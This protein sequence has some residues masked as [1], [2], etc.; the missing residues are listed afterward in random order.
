MMCYT[1]GTVD[2]STQVRKGSGETM[3][4][5]LMQCHGVYSVAGQTSQCPECPKNVPV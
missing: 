5:D 1:I 2:V 3:M 4:C